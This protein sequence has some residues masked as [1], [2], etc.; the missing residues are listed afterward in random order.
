MK[1]AFTLQIND[2][3][4][5]FNLIATDG[6]CYQLND[7]KTS[8]L[9]VVFFTCNHCPNLFFLQNAVKPLLRKGFPYKKILKIRFQ[10]FWKD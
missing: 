1:L 9:L 2:K 6:I 8:K 5:N 10:T 7:F 3:A 4:P